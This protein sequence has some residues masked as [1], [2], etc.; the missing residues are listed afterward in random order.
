MSELLDD[1]LSRAT[2]VVFDSPPLLPVTDAAILSSLT[3]G[4]LLVARVGKTRRDALAHSAE[5]LRRVGASILGVVLNRVPARKSGG[6]YGDGYQYGGY[7]TPGSRAIDLDKPPAAT[8]RAVNALLGKSGK[9]S[10]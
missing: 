2:V 7:Y 8:G 9:S 1:L 4:A 3:D 6:S 5:A 10:T